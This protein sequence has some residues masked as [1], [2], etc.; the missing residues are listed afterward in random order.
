VFTDAEI[1]TLVGRLA[2]RARPHRIIVFGSYAKG[3]ATATSDL[4][5]LVVRETDRPM[6]QRADDLTPICNGYLIPIDL[7][8]YTPE[9]VREYSKEDYHFLQTVVRTGKVVYDASPGP[10]RA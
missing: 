10:A 9:E 2:A 8:V 7:H 3:T 6:A 4:D 5:L 1:D